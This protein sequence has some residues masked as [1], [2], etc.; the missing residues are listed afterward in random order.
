MSPLDSLTPAERARQLANPDGAIGLAIAAYLND[1]N[2][3]GNAATVA[4]LAI[5]PGNA[6]L[7]IGFGNGRT[8]AEVLR[9]ADGVRYTGIDH[10]ATMVAEASRF[11][12]DMAD[13][14][15]FHLAAAD[16][17]PFTGASFDRVFSIGVIHFWTDPVASLKEVRRVMRPGATM[18]MGCLSPRGASGIHQPAFGFHLRDPETWEALTRAAGFT[19]ARAEERPI[20]HTAPDGSLSRRYLIRLTGSA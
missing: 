13:R 9:Q 5:Q 19:Q 20:D 17:M 15:S 3:T 2:K 14:A 18:I 11:N 7:E 4:L 12:A 10:S 1:H 6:V 8:A 16:R